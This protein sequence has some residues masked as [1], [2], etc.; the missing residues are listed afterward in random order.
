MR[1]KEIR[2]DGWRSRS[3]S[4]SRSAGASKAKSNLVQPK[5][6]PITPNQSGSHLLR[7]QTRN[8]EVGST[9]GIVDGTSRKTGRTVQKI[10]P[11]LNRIKPEL[12]QI[13]P[14]PRGN[15]ENRL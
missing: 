7:T 12:N 10:K 13:K 3:N 11:Q 15:F 5:S 6:K 1:L 8:I 9:P 14:L 4:E 2:A